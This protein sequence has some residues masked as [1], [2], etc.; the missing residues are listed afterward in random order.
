MLRN[1]LMNV[2]APKKGVPFFNE[3]Y[4]VE[5]ISATIEVGNN[6]AQSTGVRLWL[7]L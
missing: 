1:M 7:V 5:S 4:C 6:G 3:I 2:M